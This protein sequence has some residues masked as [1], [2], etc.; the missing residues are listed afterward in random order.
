MEKGCFIH[1]QYPFRGLEA[2]NLLRKIVQNETWNKFDYIVCTSDPPDEDLSYFLDQ[3]IEAYHTVASVNRT[4]YDLVRMRLETAEN[5]KHSHSKFQ[6]T[7]HGKVG[8][9]ALLAFALALMSKDNSSNIERNPLIQNLQQVVNWAT[10]FMSASKAKGKRH[11]KDDNGG[12]HKPKPKKARN[13]QSDYCYCNCKTN[14]HE[15]YDCPNKKNV[16]AFNQS[17]EG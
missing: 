1:H 16:S 12:I 4:F 10:K 3:V 5:V 9:E 2:I 6:I 13:F 8:D 17:R 14:N 15:Y 7:L 11:H